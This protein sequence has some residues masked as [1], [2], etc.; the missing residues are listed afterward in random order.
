VQEF[1]IRVPAGFKN[2]E[3][4][5]PNIRRRE[6]SG[7]IWTIGLQ[8][9]VWGGYTLVVTYDYPFDPNGATLPVGGIH[10]SGVERETGSIA[11]TTAA[12]LQLD[13]KNPGGSLRR[14]DE[15]ELSPTDRSF[16]TRAVVLAYHYTGGDSDL[17]VDAKHYAEVPVLQA[18]ADRT[19]ITSVLTEDGQMLT[20]AS[21]MVKNNEKQFQQF[22]LPSHASLWGCYVNSQPVKPERDGDSVLVSLPRDTDR[23]QTFTVDIMYAQT[24]GAIAAALGKTLALDAPRT[25]VP[26]TYAEWQLFVPPSFR[27]SDFSGS[28]NVAQGTTY[29][30]FDAWSKFL[31]FYGQVL[32]EAGGAILVIGLLAFLVIALVISAARR[33]WNGVLTLL[34]VMVILTILGSMLLP[35]LSA[36]KR[37]A[38]R[39][40][41]VNNLKEVGLAARIYSGDNNDR[42]PN[43]FDDMKNELGSDKITYDVETGQRFTYLGGGM[44]LGSLKPDSV[45]A[46]SPI[47][48]GHCEVLY[49]DGSVAQISDGAFAEL[50]QRGLVEL[51]APNDPSLEQPKAIEEETFAK[52]TP[53]PSAAP[54]SGVAQLGSVA[55]SVSASDLSTAPSTGLVSGE[56]VNAAGGMPAVG[57]QPPPSSP[58]T[59]AGIRSIRIDLPESGQP[60]LFTKVLNLRDEPLSIR[61]RIMPLHTFQTF[62]MIWQTGVFLIGLVVWWIQWRRPSRHSFIL[63]LSLAMMLGSVCSLL[64]QWRALHD[65]LIIGFPVLAVAIIALL[66]WKYWPRSNP[67]ESTTPTAPVIEPDLPGTAFPSATAAIVLVLA[68]SL[69]SAKVAGAESGSQKMA[70]AQA[71]IVFAKYSATVSDRVAMVDATL[72]FSAAQAGQT[73]PLFSD[74]VAVEKYFVKCGQAELIRD[75]G[76]L[77]VK[78]GRRVTLLEIHLLVKISGDVTKRELGF[79]I[80]PALSS[81]MSFSLDEPD[82]DVDFPSAV[83]FRRVLD[84]EQTRVEAVVG[85]ASRVDL[86]WTPRMKRADEIATTVFCQDAALVTFGGGV[87][88][89]RT[90]L[91]YQIS[92]GE[93]R[94]A[95]ISLPGDQRLLRVDGDGILTWQIKY[96]HG[97]QILTVSLLKGFSPSWRLAIETEK[98]LGALPATLTLVLPHALDVKRETG[99]IALRGG[100]ELGLSVESADGLQRIDPDSFTSIFPDKADNLSSVFQFSR[101]EFMLRARVAAVLPEIEA[102]VRNHFEVG[103][104]QISLSATI[105]YTIKHAGV[106]GL[107]VLLPDG[108][109]TEHVTGDGIE[110]QSERNENGQRTLEVALKDRTMGAYSLDLELVRDYRP[111]PPSLAIAGVYPLNTSKLTGF[112]A[113]TTEPG[114]A[115]K[116]GSFDGLTEI[117]AVT[118]PDFSSV[119]ANGGSVLAYKFISSHP[120]NA[121][122]WKLSLETGIV[123]AWVRSE[124]V[125]SIALTESLVS[126][127]AL[128]RYDIANAPVKE[129][130]LRVPDS[131]RNVEI[132][133][134]NIRN[135]EQDGN[136][137]RVQLQNPARG[138]YTLTV[139]WEQAAPAETNALDIAGVSADE[140]ESESGTLAISARAPLQ[141]SEAAAVDLQRVD[142][143]D[144]P[145][146]AG[147]PDPATALV[148]HYV[149]PGY[150]LS[151]SLRQLGEADVLQA[152]V[153]NAHFTSVVAADGQ[154]MTEMSLSLRDNGRQFLQLELP[155]GATVWSAFVAG[156]AVRPS[157]RDGK[158]LLPV[159]PSTADAGA[160]PVELTYVGSA[161]FPGVRGKIDFVSPSF[162]VPLKNT[163]WEIY[164]PPDYDYQAL[165]G[166]MTRETAP[167][168]ES[169]TTS[170]SILDYSRLEQASKSE[171]KNDA[172][173]DMSE[174]RRQ[175]AGG[176]VREAGESL[177]LAR[178]KLPSGA[179]ASG[180]LKQ[181]QKELQAAQASNL[182]NA[183][184]DFT[185]RNSAQA[186]VGQSGAVPSRF[187]LQ[188][189]NADAGEQWNKLLEAQEITAAKVQP[190]HVNLP[191]RGLCF[192]FTQVLQTETEKPLTIQMFASSVKAFSWPSRILEGSLAFFLLWGAVLTLIR[193]T[194]RPR[195][196][197]T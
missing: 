121:P 21:F 156:Q 40:S 162:D 84:K 97:S 85:S 153:E 173:R 27:L 124:I 187:G 161:P 72:Q 63:S 195:K 166:S 18:V 81:Q 93:L 49:A 14:I 20:Q 13:P 106:F 142:A 110:Q 152:I 154:M 102:V 105:N 163:R 15:T 32:H 3:F 112:L 175:L 180:D 79:G 140:V 78:L 132:T 30:L 88:N 71:S 83:S 46:Y 77:S 120:Q 37:K 181:L 192:A 64:V 113:V 197:T 87:M 151:L 44:S 111:L 103:A 148:Y 28:M 109:R 12:S 53:V 52:R 58:A 80:P 131:F 74:D 188:Y 59:A 114:V 34:V 91:D 75:G 144:F 57:S 135:R 19:Q 141:V 177:S 182:V 123:A 100:E 95:R 150:H 196:Q 82:A 1:K 104:D 107:Q 165:Q 56:S 17:S 50:S 10:A 31:T 117:P 101:A 99:L 133:G 190:L 60:F 45:L 73:I 119:A 186:G 26:N 160:T 7:E 36:A 169:A 167:A 33:G 69:T 47:V 22:H 94:E 168:V 39:I 2:V 115:A 35:A 23:D 55:G 116:T 129:L 70:G 90:V 51:A 9:K 48:N 137:W 42:L 86:S 147:N 159:E 38:Q 136:I 170:F 191:V 25:D 5:G 130:R 149:R 6:Q 174:A 67:G 68:M 29:E 118:L 125:N 179:Y 66:I 8:D 108:Y 16:I 138:L 4:T 127:R 194:P 176:N 24:N 184:S 146:W 43:S 54:P 145:D 157:V 155:T 65:A 158:L 61:A 11:I 171:E 122:E 178:S 98:N 128:V 139:T 193:L 126:G 183:Q 92:Q 189:D 143:G 96:D 134:G 62:Q 164:L 89:T 172:L 76:S 185:V 41:S